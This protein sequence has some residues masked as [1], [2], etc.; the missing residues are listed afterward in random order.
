MALT[1]ELKQLDPQQVATALDSSAERMGLGVVDPEDRAHAYATSSAV[2]DILERDYPALAQL[3]KDIG[4]KFGEAG[5]SEYDTQLIRVGATATV[6]A[7]KEC[8]ENELFAPID[9]Q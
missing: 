5:G 1:E 7:L 3:I 6:L 2:R 4:E 9:A 8:G